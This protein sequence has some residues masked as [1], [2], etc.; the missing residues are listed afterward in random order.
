MYRVPEIDER[1][2]PVAR[3]QK[4]FRTSPI[5]ALVENEESELLE[6]PVQIV[7]VGSVERQ[8]RERLHIRQHQIKLLKGTIERLWR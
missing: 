8:Q 1:T 4:W 3:K 6:P 2:L 5:L 7:E